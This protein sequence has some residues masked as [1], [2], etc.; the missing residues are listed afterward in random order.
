[1][2]ASQFVSSPSTGFVVMGAVVLVGAIPFAVP[3]RE[4]QEEIAPVRERVS[5]RQT[6]ASF[7]VDPR[8][9]PDFF[10]AFLA[11]LVLIVGYWSI[12]SFQLYIL[13]DYIGLGLAGANALYPVTTAVLGIGIIVALVPSGLLS[14]R[15]GRR[16]PFVIVSSVVV[17]ASAV[18]PIVSPTV[19]GAVVSVGLG[20][21][22]IGV[23]LAV[24]QA[25]MTQV[26][27]NTSDAGRDLGV[28]N[29]A[30]AG[31][32]VVAPLVA[33]I[34]IGIAG[35]PALYGFAAVLAV[36]AALAVLPIKS[37]R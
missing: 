25:L 1:V 15:I 5:W 14:D 11:R 7:F 21:L 3:M 8:Q 35:Y 6:L 13:D 27:P 12:L 34:V 37:V 17:A 32:Q 22:G 10:W 16:K 20:G 24:D 2:I 23:Y 9:H 36:L 18:V 31:G 26:L 19:T 30:Q 33:S 4:R 28:L 29:I